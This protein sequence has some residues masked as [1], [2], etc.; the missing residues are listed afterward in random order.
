[1]RDPKRIPR[2]LKELE[3]IWKDAPDLRFCQLM[4]NLGLIEDK[5]WNYEDDKL[6]MELKE[7]KWKQK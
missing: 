6:E 3:R 1:M 2:I 7:F 4:I 5:K